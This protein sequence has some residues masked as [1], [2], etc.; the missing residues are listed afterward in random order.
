VEA[1]NE[2]RMR[3]AKGEGLAGPML[4]TTIF[5]T[6]AVQLIQVGEESGAL[7]DMLLRVAEIYDGEVERTL[8]RMLSLL[9]PLITIGLGIVIAVIIGAMVSAILS[10]YDLPI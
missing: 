6:L 4:Q 2:V 7:E 3:L 9:V 8:Q 5:P 10:S 1:L